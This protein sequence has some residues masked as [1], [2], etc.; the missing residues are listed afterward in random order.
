MEQRAIVV[1]ARVMLRAGVVVAVLLGCRLAAADPP[2][3]KPDAR[4]DRPTKGGRTM[5]LADGLVGKTAAQV[6]AKRGTPSCKSPTLWRFWVPDG[7]AYE[8][9][10]VSVWFDRGRVRRAIAVRYITGE[11]CM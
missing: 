7:C 3:C 2:R 11:E 9:I 1:H 4:F 8:K 5:G 6:I 10:V